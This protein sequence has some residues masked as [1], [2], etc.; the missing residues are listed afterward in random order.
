MELSGGSG[1]PA[2]NIL[3]SINAIYHE[4]AKELLSKKHVV[5][6][7]TLIETLGAGPD[8][9]GISK[10]KTRSKKL[11][12]T[13]IER[14][15]YKRIN[16]SAK[17]NTETITKFLEDLRDI[18]TLQAHYRAMEVA[19][20][21]ASNIANA[22][23]KRKYRLI[24]SQ[25]EVGIKQQDSHRIKRKKKRKRNINN[26]TNN[27]KR[28]KAYPDLSNYNNITYLHGT[29]TDGIHEYLTRLS[30]YKD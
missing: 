27:L 5:C 8:S 4:G 7:S 30:N 28:I 23:A 2:K 16:T 9:Q 21:K 22:A 18:D 14:K 6:S 13:K 1:L 10:G 25:D 12:L 11:R 17:R 29:V 15:G 20:L 3:W 24:S 19:A 26:N